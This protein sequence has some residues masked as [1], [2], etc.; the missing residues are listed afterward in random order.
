MRRR[1]PFDRFADRAER[2][3]AHGWFFAACVG[4]VLVWAPT[5]LFLQVDTWQLVINTT[6][7]IIT[8]LL[9][10]LLTNAQRRF[11]ERVDEKLDRLLE[12]R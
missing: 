9:L 10:A 5:G 1:G 12:R 11:E 4:L 7:T 6:T 2:V 3:V 8:F